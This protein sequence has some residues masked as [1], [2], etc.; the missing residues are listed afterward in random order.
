MAVNK[1]LNLS[2]QCALAVQKAKAG[3]DYILGTNSLFRAW[4]GTGTGCPKKPW[5]C[6][7]PGSVQALIQW[8]FDGPC[9]VGG[10][11]GHGRG[12]KIR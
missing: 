10:V 2:W 6:S 12:F 8:G 9:P 3:L 5:M 11:P 1:K 7:S 4:Y